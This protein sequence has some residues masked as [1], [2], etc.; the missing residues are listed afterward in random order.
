MRM[1]RTQSAQKSNKYQKLIYC[2]MLLKFDTH[3][4]LLST[5]IKQSE[6]K[7]VILLLQCPSLAL[8]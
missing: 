3:T 4:L 6:A 1:Y 7:I 2:R 5:R 8:I